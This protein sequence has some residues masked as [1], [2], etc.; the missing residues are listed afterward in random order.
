MLGGVLPA[1]WLHRETRQSFP[2]CLAP[3]LGI[4]ELM[5]IDTA[6]LIG[7]LL[8]IAKVRVGH[9]LVFPLT[10]LTD[11]AGQTEMVAARGVGH[12]QVHLRGVEGR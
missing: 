3:F 11:L 2:E 1:G 4:V 7:P 8:D 5:L 10:Q 12:G 9:L 6:I